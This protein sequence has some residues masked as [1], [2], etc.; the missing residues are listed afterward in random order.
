MD[1]NPSVDY[2]RP[3]IARV[4]DFFLGGDLNSEADRQVAEKILEAMP[5]LP[6]I[7]RAN[8]A[9]AVRAVR[10][11]V[12]AGIRQ[13]LDLGSGLA[14]TGAAHEV[15]RDAGADARVLYVDNDPVVAAHNRLLAPGSNCAVL[16]ADLRDTA[17]VLGSPQAADLFDFDQP[18]GVLMIAVLH[19]VPHADRPGDIVARYRDALAPGSCLALTHA[20]NA[21]RR[22]STFQAARVYSKDVAEIHL[23]TRTEI[24]AFLDGW[25]LEAPGLV[26]APDWHPDPATLVRPTVRQHGVAAVARKPLP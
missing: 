24:A 4:Y 23:R 16:R 18:I 9:F 5:D 6:D 13:F 26:P 3:S 1:E 21:E 8:R 17:E 25:D 20:E 2:A 11:L 10:Y 19:F 22:P 12:E 7:L 15:V 14:T